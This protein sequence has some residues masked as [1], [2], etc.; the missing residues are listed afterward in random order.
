MLHRALN[1]MPHA[2][3]SCSR[4]VAPKAP[5]RLARVCVVW[6]QAYACKRR[7][8]AVLSHP[9]RGG[10]P[11]RPS[12]TS[13]RLPTNSRPDIFFQVVPRWLTPTASDPRRRWQAWT[14]T[15][16]CASNLCYRANPSHAALCQAIP[17]CPGI[18]Y[19]EDLANEEEGPFM[20][21][22]EEVCHLR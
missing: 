14:R 18:V 17:P 11:L 2:L 1:H 3:A 15:T 6:P 7:V 12:L 4:V 13:M 8:D 9:Q 22:Q 16:R 20:V 5:P 21:A 10:Q 19:E